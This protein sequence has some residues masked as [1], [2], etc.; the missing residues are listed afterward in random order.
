M[1]FI[2]PGPRKPKNAFTYL[3]FILR[4]LIAMEKRGFT[5]HLAGGQSITYKARLCITTGDIPGVADLCNHT[6]HTSYFGC[7]I[8]KI[9]TTRHRGGM[10]FNSFSED[11]LEM[12]PTRTVD[13]YKV[14]NTEVI[15]SWFFTLKT[16]II[17]TP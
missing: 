17:L 7:R 1:P 2:A 15:L 14:D 9:I 13:D 4:E 16:A 3:Y 8:C 10:Y 6:G 12:F 5:V 11:G